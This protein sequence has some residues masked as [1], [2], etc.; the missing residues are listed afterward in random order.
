MPIITTAD[1]SPAATGLEAIAPLAEPVRRAV[2]LAVADAANAVGREEVAAAV[3]ISRALATFHLER[4]LDAGLIEAEF[5]KGMLNG[6]PRRGR[7][8]KR[9]RPAQRDIAISVPPRR[10]ELAGA[11]FAD[12]LAAMDRPAALDAVAADYGRAIGRRVRTRVAEV[13]DPAGAVGVV[14][15]VGALKGALAEEG[16]APRE[17]GV[18]RI[19]LGNCPFDALARRHRDVVCPTNLALFNGLLDEAA[20]AGVSAVLEPSPERCCVVLT[21]PTAPSEPAG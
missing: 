11:I 12:A 14:G 6:R 16:F 10:Y 9:Y 1:P 20:I 5:Q 7:P 21:L 8:Q 3:G 4:L 2:F 15:A 17:C 19:C 18:G 13:P